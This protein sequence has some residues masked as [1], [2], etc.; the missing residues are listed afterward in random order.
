MAKIQFFGHSF[1]KIGFPQGNVLIDPFLSCNPPNPSLERLVECAAKP[2]DL[3]DISII[4]VSHE[5]FDHFEKETIEKIANKEGA[6]VVSHESILQK[7]EIP[8]NLKHAISL[9]RKATLRNI[10]I[11]ALPAHHPQAF[12][13]LGFLISANNNSVYHAGDTALLDSFSEIKADVALLPIGGSMTMD[14]VDAVRAVKTMK[15]DYV[16]PMHYNTFEVIKADPL[17]FKQKIEKSIL[18]TKPV[19]LEPGKSFSFK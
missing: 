3:K 17:E 13:P 8:K 6:L 14:L 2:A 7:L 5:H 16:I 19:I 10:E 12:Y 11:E 4:L 9:N 18:K 15:P 1:F